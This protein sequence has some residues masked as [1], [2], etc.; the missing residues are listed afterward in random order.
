M[1]KLERL[2][3]LKETIFNYIQ[4][5]QLIYISYVKRMNQE[6]LPKKVMDFKSRR[7]T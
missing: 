6:R 4:K 2:I 7:K 1:K 3:K 5:E